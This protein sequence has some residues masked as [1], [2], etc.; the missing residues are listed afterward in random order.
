MFD[1]DLSQQVLGLTTPWKTTYVRL[2]VALTEIAVHVEHTP[3][4]VAG[5]ARGVAV[6]WRATTMPPSGSGGISIPTSSTRWSTLVFHESSVQG[7]V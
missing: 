4:A 6:S 2:D 7:T 5:T 1:T 3:R